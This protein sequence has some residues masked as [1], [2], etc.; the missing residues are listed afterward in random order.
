MDA[1]Q[2]LHSK[3]WIR[4]RFLNFLSSHLCSVEG[5]FDSLLASA[6][7]VVCVISPSSCVCVHAPLLSCVWLFVTP[8]T[9]ARQ[10][11]LS[12]EFS[13]QEYW[14]LP[15]PTHGIFP[16]QQSNPCLLHWQVDFL[17]LSHLGSPH[18]PLPLN[19]TVSDGGIMSYPFGRFLPWRFSN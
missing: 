15:F 2:R 5:A 12:M 13:R 7:F 9:T 10:A 18:P 6:C 11:P 1:F 19:L 17:Q 16:T 4:T 14:G 8:W 3:W